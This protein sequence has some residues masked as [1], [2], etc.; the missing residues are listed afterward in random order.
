MSKNCPE[1]VLPLNEYLLLDHLVAFLSIIIGL[2]KT[3]VGGLV[4]FVVLNHMV[5]D[6]REHLQQPCGI[7]KTTVT[8][9]LRQ[10]VQ[11]E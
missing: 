1:I 6:V 10:T 7:E 2:F 3:L 11:M 5:T 9:H 4:I 8:R